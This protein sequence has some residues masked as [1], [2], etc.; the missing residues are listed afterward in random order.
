MT[1]FHQITERESLRKHVAAIHVGGKL[2]LL[3]R[4]LS[5]CLLLHA[6]DDLLTKTSHRIDAETLCAMSGYASRDHDTLKGALR[7]LAETTAE[8]N[9]L[10][11][12]GEE[13]WGIS[14]MISY[15]KLAS[16]VCEYAYSAPLA[17]KLYD[18][19]VFSMINMRIQR[20]FT[21]GHALALYENCFRFVRT[22]STGWWELDVFRRLMG[23]HDSAYYEDFSKLNAKIIKPSVKEVNS[24]SD[25]SLV[26]EVRRESR[27]VRFI[28]FL[29][30]RNGQETLFDLGDDDAIR[31]TVAYRRLVENGISRRLAQRWIAEHGEEYVCEK[32]D[33]VD[34]ERRKGR[35]R[36]TP[37]GYLSAAINGDFKVVPKKEETATAPPA[38]PKPTPADLADEARAA[39]LQ[40]DAEWRAACLKIIDANLEKRSPASRKAVKDRF[41]RLLEDDFERH[42]FKQFGWHARGAFAKIHAF[43]A[44]L[45][46]EG[47]PARPDDVLETD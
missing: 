23:V 45:V 35:V 34:G 15:A 19:S 41:T 28:R 25:I 9:M 26:A 27:K 10:G 20:N 32:L 17:A 4:K 47:L 1:K 18:P 5:N 39:S 44:D 16:G 43:W 38:P 29:I 14:S 22:G 7:A 24:V 30:T 21:S 46:P 37:A 13:E 8:W 6:Y 42:Q 40:R 36:K 31:K 11:D 12:N 2:S 33:F 3:Q